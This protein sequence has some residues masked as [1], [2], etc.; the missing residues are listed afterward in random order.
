M[1]MELRCPRCACY[2]GAPAGA[3]YVD[4][5]DRMIAE[6]PWFGLARGATFADMILATLASRGT[7]RCPECAAGV[8]VIEQDEFD[9]FPNTP[10]IPGQRQVDLLELPI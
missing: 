10:S 5:I 3:P 1:S 2:V 8:A 6:G 4:I 9:D 7:I